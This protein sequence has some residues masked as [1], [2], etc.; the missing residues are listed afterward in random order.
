MAQGLQA[1]PGAIERDRAF[2]PLA[3][4]V[5]RGSRRTRDSI[6]EP[7][8]REEYQGNGVVA[9][10]V[11]RGV[12]QAELQ[13]GDTHE[14]INI[15]FDDSQIVNRQLP[16][17]DVD[18]HLRVMTNRVSSFAFTAKSAEVRHVGCKRVAA[19]P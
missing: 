7:N 14:C 3:R 16:D 13:E 9:P 8:R 12:L 4:Q 19:L 2:N 10:R 1:R 15:M 18:P 5:F 17:K 6:E 11:A